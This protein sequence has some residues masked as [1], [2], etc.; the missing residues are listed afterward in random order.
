MSA[1]SVDHLTSSSGD[2]E[3]LQRELVELKKEL[4][5]LRAKEK[6]DVDTIEGLRTQAIESARRAEEARKES[7]KLRG[8]VDRYKQ[9]DG[10]WIKQLDREQQISANLDREVKLWRERATEGEHA[11]QRLRA[12]HQQELVAIRAALVERKDAPSSS[13]GN[14][15][16][17]KEEAA[18]VNAKL[19]NDLRLARSDV[20]L[21]REENKRLREQMA[22]EKEKHNSSVSASAGVSEQT[23]ATLEVMMETWQKE[24]D[25]DAQSRDDLLRMYEAQLKQKDKQIEE[26]NEQLEVLRVTMEAEANEHGLKNSF[27]KIVSKTKQAATGAAPAPSTSNTS[28]KTTKP[29]D[30]KSKN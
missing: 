21:L 30:P 16:K 6:L 24:R 13:N 7:E 29:K 2:A 20:E 9:I 12:D 22:K 17:E 10:D 8:E 28:A 25:R 18:A 27:Y 1:G 3:S 5:K 4:D 19:E 15:N 14:N 26:L 23:M 11:L